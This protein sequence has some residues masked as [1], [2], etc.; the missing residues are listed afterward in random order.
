MTAPERDTRTLILDAARELFVARGYE[1]VS[2]RKIAELVGLSPTA[3]YFHFRDKETLFRELCL[4][5]FALLAQE[6]VR[7]RRIDDPVERL[8]QM[9]YAYVEFGLANPNHYRLMFMTPG[10]PVPPPE[11]FPEIKGDP[12]QDSYALVLETIAEGL[13]A[14]CF[15][16]EYHDV[17][18]LTQFIWAA[19]HGAVSLYIAKRDNPWVEWR[20]IRDTARRLIDVAIDGVTHPTGAA[21]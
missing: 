15:L 8:R 2:M 20:P 11:E 21:R 16:P 19:A 6:M 4:A 17:V 12:E 10:G 9:G 14:G 1:Q 18:A 5:D 3:I 13:A 7:L